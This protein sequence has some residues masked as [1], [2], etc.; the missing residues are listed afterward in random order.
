MYGVVTRNPEELDWEV[1]DRGFYE[2]KDVTGRQT[3]PVPTRTNMISCFGDSA[4]GD[5]DPSLV[6][7]SRAGE[8]ATRDSQY[9]DWGFICPS[10][11][12]YREE[13][14]ELIEQTVSVNPDVRIDDIGF[15]R[16]EYCYC[17]TCE[18][19]FTASQYNDRHRWRASVVTKF[20]ERVRDVV[21]GHLST[22]VYPDPYPGHLEARSGVDVDALASHVDEFVIPIYD[23]SYST[24][25]WIE[26]LA[27]GF[28][29]RLSKPFSVELYAVDLDVDALSRAAEVA[30]AY[31]DDVFFAY[32]AATARQA[33][34]R[35]EK[36]EA[37]NSHEYESAG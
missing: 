1:F 15:P 33:I 17:S 9:F 11:P 16:A 34:E 27:T 31:A 32:D 7:V 14:I 3:D 8:R 28:R 22:T 13:L 37:A 35:L 6:P 2:V 4:R 12:T 29:D 19:R 20:V 18:E 26:V 10:R 21:P 30:G 25:Y 36:A 23:M 5:E 24:T